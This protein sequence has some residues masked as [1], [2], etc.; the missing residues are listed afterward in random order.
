MDVVYRAVVSTVLFMLCAK[1]MR[2]GYARKLC[3]RL[4]A[5]LGICVTL[6][7]HVPRTRFLKTVNDDAR[8]TMRGTMHRT[9]RDKSGPWGVI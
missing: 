1:V 4:C 6:L 9:M 7:L 2:E 3:A 8:G 5:Q